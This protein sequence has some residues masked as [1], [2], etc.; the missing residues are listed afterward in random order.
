[1]KSA[2]GVMRPAGC[3][4][5]VRAADPNA[6]FERLEAHPHAFRTAHGLRTAGNLAVGQI[7]L[8]QIN[9]SCTGLAG[10]GRRQCM[11]ENSRLYLIAAS[12]I[13]EHRALKFVEHDQN[14]AQCVVC[15]IAGASC[16]AHES[17]VQKATHAAPF[18]VEAEGQ[19]PM[20][21]SDQKHGFGRDMVTV[22]CD[23]Y[24]GEIFS[25][26]WDPL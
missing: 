3:A 11:R 21:V 14:R 15:H 6:S 17:Q 7:G 2:G 24:F 18:I 8:D 20:Q 9:Q 12:S 23:R 1:M 5:I 19:G 4:Q 26:M 25:Q 13:A 22:R 10:I 16:A